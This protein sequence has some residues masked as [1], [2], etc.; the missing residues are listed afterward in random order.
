MTAH[1]FRLHPLAA[2]LRYGTRSAGALASGLIPGLVL[3]N[4]TGGVVVGGDVGI[5]SQGSRMTVTQTSQNA[6]VNWQT[7]SVDSNEYVVFNQASASSAILNRVVGGLP[8]S[9]LGNISANGRV[10]LINP[11]GVMFG[12]NARID[13]GALVT[14]TMDISNADFNAGRYRFVDGHG[15]GGKIENAGVITAADGGFVVLAADQ[16]RNS[17]LIQAQLGDVVLASGSAMTLNLDGSGLVNFS[18]DG[19]ALSDAAG[20]DNL[21]DLVANGGRVLMSADVARALMSSVVNNTGRVSARSIED[22]DG[23]I[24]LTANGGAITQAGSLDASGVAGADGG[25]VRIVGDGDIELATGSL[26]QARAGSAEAEGGSV[27]V[28]GDGK[29]EFAAG[30][31]IDAGGG[32]AG[33]AELSGHDTLRIRGDVELGHDGTLLIDPTNLTI[34]QGSGG[35]FSSSY[36]GSATVYEAFIENQLRNGSNVFIAADQQI[37]IG[38]L[39]ANSG[40]G[41]LDGRSSGYGGSLTLGIGSVGVSSYGGPVGIDTYFSRGNGAPGS[42][43]FFDNTGNMIAVDGDLNVTG[44]YSYGAFNLGSLQGAN[45]Y[46]TAVESITTA[47]LRASASSGQVNI[48]SGG[49]DVT[50]GA[51]SA[52]QIRLNLDGGILSTGAITGMHG[53]SCCAAYLSIDLAN[54]ARIGTLGEVTLLGGAGTVSIHADHDLALNGVAINAGSNSG[55]TAAHGNIQLVSDDGS[56]TVSGATLFGNLDATLY[57]G[58]GS[59][60]PGT[61]SLSNSTV[62]GDT[63]LYAYYGAGVDIEGVSISNGSLSATASGGALRADNLSADDIYLANDQYLGS[64]APTSA[65][66]VVQLGTL[67]A[68]AGNV[69]VHA[70]GDLLSIDP[71]NDHIQASGYVSLAAGSSYYFDPVSGSYENLAGNMTLG[72]IAGASIDLSVRGGT[73]NTGALTASAGG[74]NY[75]NIDIELYAAG[76]NSAAIGALGPMRITG[77]T[78]LVVINSDHSLSVSGLDINA[79][80]SITGTGSS[81]QTVYGTINLY[82][83]DALT[84]DSSTMT[85]SI[86]ATTGS[87]GG[88][89]SLQNSDVVGSVYLF[90]SSGALT[91]DSLTLTGTLNATTGQN[92]GLMSVHNSN[93]TGSVYLTGANAGGID[94]NN[95]GVTGGS[96]SATAYNSSGIVADELS[97]ESISLSV[98]ET[99]GSSMPALPLPTMQV[100]NLTATNG[101]INL[102]AGGDILSIDPDN[103][104]LQASGGVA[105]NAGSATYYEPSSSVSH[106]IGG[107]I[108][109]GNIIAGGAISLQNQHAS[110]Y[111]VTPDTGSHD[112]TFGNLTS[113]GDSIYVYAENGIHV[114]DVGSNV[115]SAARALQLSAGYV[116]YSSSSPQAFVGNIDIGAAQADHIGLSVYGGTINTG[117]LTAFAGNSYSYGSDVDIELRDAGSQHGAIGTLGP[118]RVSGDAGN[119]SIFADHDLTVSGLDIDAGSSVDGGLGEIDISAGGGSLSVTNSTLRGYVSA[120]L[121]GGGSS[122][123]YGGNLFSA[124]FANATQ[125]GGSSSGGTLHVDQVQVDGDISLLTSGAQSIEIGSLS[126]TGAVQAG[127]YSGQPSTISALDVTG[128]SIT[129]GNNYASGTDAAGGG[130]VLIG[131]LHATNGAI[132]INAGRNVGII[133]GASGSLTATGEIFVSAGNYLVYTGSSSSMSAH[134]GGDIDLGALEGSQ[135]TVQLFG[136]TLNIGSIDVGGGSSY[137]NVH[138][139]LDDGSSGV[140]SIGSL[141]PVTVHGSAGHVLIESSGDLDIASIGLIDAGSSAGYGGVVSGDVSLRALDGNTR[142]DQLDVVGNL[143]IDTVNLGAFSGSADR[144]DLGASGTLSVYSN[145]TAQ[146]FNATAGSDLYVEGDVNAGAGGAVSLISTN[147]DVDGDGSLTTAD[148][149][150]QANS[151]TFGDLALSGALSLTT[152][153][154]AIDLGNINAGSIDLHAATDILT[155]DLDVGTLGAVALMSDTGTISTGG[156]TSHDLSVIA[157]ELDFGDLSITGALLL[158]ASGGNLSVGGINAASVDLDAASALSVNGAINSAGMTRLSGSTLNINGAINGASIDLEG[159]PVSGFLDLTASAGNIHLGTSESTLDNVTMQSAGDIVIDNALNATSIQLTAGH[160]VSAADLSVAGNLLDINAGN[161]VFAGALSAS[162]GGSGSPVYVH[163]HTDVGNINTGAIMA[164]AANDTA[165]VFLDSGHDI[166]IAGDLSIGGH[167]ATQTADGFYTAA[168]GDLISRGGT[169]H[170]GGDVTVVGS[171]DG[172]DLADGETLHASELLLRGRNGSAVSVDGNVFVSGSADNITGAANTTVLG[173]YAQIGVPDSDFGT[174][175]ASVTVHDVAV[176]GT[177]FGISLGTNADSET[178]ALTLVAPGGAVTAGNLSAAGTIAVETATTFTAGTLTAQNIDVTAGTGISTLAVQSDNG[179]V[180][181]ISSNGAVASGTISGRDLTATGDSLDLSDLALSGAL[182]LTAGNGDLTTGQIEAGSIM[183]SATGNLFIGGPATASGLITLDGMH[184]SFGGAVTGASIDVAGLQ[185]DGIIDMQATDGDLQLSGPVSGSTVDLDAAGA[186][187]VD[188]TVASGGAIAL[189]GGTVHLHDSIAGQS[190]SISGGALDGTLN[191]SASGGDIELLTVSNNVD[192]V[193]LFAAGDIVLSG[194]VSAAGDVGIA[195]NGSVDFGDISGNNIVIDSGAA[196][197]LSQ[198]SA[199]TATGS[200]HLG[201]GTYSGSSLVIDSQGLDLASDLDFATLSLDIGGAA[202]LNVSGV[203]L[204]AGTLSLVAS[205]GINLDNTQLLADNITLQAG[206]SLV[207]SN[208]SMDGNVV[209]TANGGAQLDHA[210]W[211]GGSASL[212]SANL[213]ASQSSFDYGQSLNFNAVSGA[214]LISNSSFNGGSTPRGNIQLQSAGN[215]QLSGSQLTGKRVVLLAG[216]NIGDNGTQTV[217][218]ASGLRAEADGNIDFAHSLVRIGTGSSGVAGDSAMLALL[219]QKAPDLLPGA[220]GPNGYFRAG[221]ISLGTLAMTG[222]YLA[223][224]GNAIDIGAVSAA[225]SHLLV[226]IRPLDNAS[227]IGVDAP[228]GTGTAIA[229]AA[230]DV[231]SF[232]DATLFAPYDASLVFG[233]GN[234]SGD[235]NIS[236]TSIDVSDASTNFLFLTTGHVNGERGL[237]TNGQVIVLAGITSDNI[238]GD[239]A[240]EIPIVSEF[241]P[242]SISDSQSLGGSQTAQNDEGND[243][244]QPVIEDAPSDEKQCN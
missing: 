85:G 141:G 125:I 229:K 186:L 57:Q 108:S 138:I 9:I 111:S 144:V 182:S 100:G 227:G 157:N 120:M 221:S 203:D 160:D 39:S 166:D 42:G 117:A 59:A 33:F 79:G 20:V 95:V 181:L 72:S 22:H 151:L 230:S 155:G 98:Y 23:E 93:V 133:D 52:N 64:G 119:V 1:R 178:G 159:G 131:Q 231:L 122:G 202:G 140:A 174:G 184:L 139:S 102:A 91:V 18:I 209:A 168:V 226:Q 127:T 45:V 204:T 154:G 208:M 78:G 94:I 86:S 145:V 24:V 104:L 142:V 27:R 241:Q 196:S 225:P 195:A 82:A 109:V 47:D 74:S 199:L 236:D 126:A 107:S 162:S 187:D 218:D 135:A 240:F 4:P 70:G 211:S 92:G 38:D 214:M 49:G 44:G 129:L 90:A 244:D 234:Y 179:T 26:T 32:H 149:T 15:G 5:D 54:D 153:I 55:S 106:N 114:R 84:I 156:I 228:A 232:N 163:V 8:S 35:S 237:Q 89:L 194:P 41:V 158:Q 165:I 25:R 66:P 29:V 207:A 175:S 17:G 193:D 242:Q 113:T 73:L 99:P 243:S 30:A 173:G 50:T 118:I 48:Q 68:S 46:L 34:A 183:M 101:D 197:T 12:Q 180:S 215:L 75:G 88:V 87:N 53:A 150:I 200:T 56:L 148:L 80:S 188:G 21:G 31:Q 201:G 137:Y 152:N 121:Y 67:N 110:Y 58:S 171:V 134:V 28:I 164:S 192:A 123:S 76:G 63:G 2:A 16:V 81:A 161:D 170:I 220:A 147:G 136:G 169:L 185:I 224:N 124:G 132:L 190:I 219:E 10:F 210:V 239:G 83:D 96:L 69:N 115:L 167:R 206:G 36:G 172:L 43:I 62:D 213:S 128:A 205:Q 112:I 37:H 6:I 176:Y 13:V 40:D 130:D 216:G 61:L 116:G 77:G 97:A 191:L 238:S 105:I 177:L 19:A 212:Q 14:S 11:Q 65:P 60:S 71:L 51:I 189:N 233:G 235:I 217:V 146:Q 103:N 143:A 198:A 223:L 3:A 222:D 7:F